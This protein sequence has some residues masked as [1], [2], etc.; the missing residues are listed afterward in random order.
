MLAQ[1][2]HPTLYDTLPRFLL[3]NELIAQPTFHVG[4]TCINYTGGN[5]EQQNCH[6]RCSCIHESIKPSLH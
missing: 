4:I 5:D 2:F 1:N 6:A 3:D